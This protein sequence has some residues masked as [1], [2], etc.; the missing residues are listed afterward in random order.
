MPG[1]RARIRILIADDHTMVREALRELLRGER[2]F[3][4]VGEAGD[5]A[6]AIHLS[7]SLRPDVLLVD[8]AM[9]RIGGLEALRELVDAQSPVRPIV[10]AA[11]IKH[12]D[13]VKALQLGARG[14]VLKDAPADVLFRSIR[15]VMEGRYWL[16]RQAAENLAGALRMVV[17]AKPPT[18]NTFG[19]T[20]RQLEVISNVIDGLT[21]KEIASTL[22]LS[23]ETVKHHL[24]Q[25]FDKL[26]VSNRVELALF[27]MHSGLV[28]DARQQPVAL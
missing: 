19:L 22:S 16:G 25:I 21:N 26:G 7:A 8:L 9:P 14:V 27:A 23:E 15:T 20:R 3:A 11:S 10:L 13:I 17:S 12:D 18:S 4:V 6:E 5:G 24:T 1:T 2:D 28:S